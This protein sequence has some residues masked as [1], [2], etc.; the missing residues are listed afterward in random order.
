[1]RVPSPDHDRPRSALE[2]RPVVDRH[3]G[4]QRHRAV[5]ERRGR[6]ARARADHD[7]APGFRE[8][9]RVGGDETVGVELDVLE[10][11]Q[12]RVHL[13]LP[14]PRPLRDLGWRAEVQP[15]HVAHA[16]AVLLLACVGEHQATDDTPNA[17]LDL[18]CGPGSTGRRATCRPTPASSFASGEPSG[19]PPPLPG[20][21]WPWL[22][23]TRRRGRAHRC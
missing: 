15:R 22:R 12:A 5:Y 13:G 14:L 21:R 18:G 9:L 20:D 19:R 6:D 10:V 2:G 8:H 1:M 17:I 7:R 16:P 3:V 23:G 11:G 4:A